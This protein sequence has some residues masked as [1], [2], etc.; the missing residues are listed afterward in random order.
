MYKTSVVKQKILETVQAYIQELNK[1][2]RMI[3]SGKLSK[4]SIEKLLK[5]G[6]IR[7]KRKFLKGI[8]KG[9]VHIE[10]ELKKYFDVFWKEKSN[11]FSALAGLTSSGTKIAKLKQIKNPIKSEILKFLSNNKRTLKNEFKFQ[12]FGGLVGLVKQVITPKDKVRK[13]FR[14]FLKNV[15]STEKEKATID[16]IISKRHELDELRDAKKVLQTAER[17]GID[18]KNGFGITNFTK[19]GMRVGI[20]MTPKVLEREKQLTDY[21]KN[22]FGIKTNLMN[23]RDLSGEYELINKLGKSGVTKLRRKIINQ[24]LKNK[25]VSVDVSTGKIETV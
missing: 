15:I 24:L 13:D 14:N 6:A 21:I 19:Y 2:E 18:L 11:E 5:S 7:D 10:R 12:K 9:N 8:V 16:A 22:A 20:H 23:Y 25:D 17:K 4:H 3:A 1:A